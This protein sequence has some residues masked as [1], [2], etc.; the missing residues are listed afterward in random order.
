MVTLTQLEYIIAV[1]ECRLA[2]VVVVEGDALVRRAC[3]KGLAE[4]RKQLV[5]GDEPGD[6]G[7]HVRRGEGVVQER[8]VLLGLREVLL[9]AQRGVDGKVVP[10]LDDPPVVVDVDADAAASG[11]NVLLS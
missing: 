10:G 3:N 11:L 2:D 8:Q 9:L 1:D 7:G 6:E 5:C 4:L